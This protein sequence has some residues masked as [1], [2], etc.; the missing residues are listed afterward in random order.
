MHGTY[1]C[2][3]RNL[4]NTQHG[5]HLKNEDGMERRIGMRLAATVY[6]AEVYPEN[7]ERV[8]SETLKQIFPVRS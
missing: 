3:Y 6:I 1:E 8:A 4:T 7:V 5:G 2:D